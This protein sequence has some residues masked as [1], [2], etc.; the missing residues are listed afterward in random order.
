MNRTSSLTPI[1]KALLDLP[2]SE[3][4][5]SSRGEISFLFLH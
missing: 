2:G 4:L 1:L 5:H 3:A